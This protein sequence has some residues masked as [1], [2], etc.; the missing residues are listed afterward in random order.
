MFIFLEHVFLNVSWVADK[1]FF[2]YSSSLHRVSSLGNIRIAVCL[3]DFDEVP[4]ILI[5]RKKSESIY[6]SFTSGYLHVLQQSQ[7]FS[8]IMVRIFK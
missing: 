6:P 8:P 4:F 2:F 5:G 7:K 1:V 3:I